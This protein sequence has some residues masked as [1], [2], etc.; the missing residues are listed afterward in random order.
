VCGGN[1]G[2]EAKIGREQSSKAEG[3][4]KCAQSPDQQIRQQK[5]PTSLAPIAISCNWNR[6]RVFTCSEPGIAGCAISFAGCVALA[7]FVLFGDGGGSGSLGA[8]RRRLLGGSITG[9]E[10]WSEGRIHGDDDVIH[11]ELCGW[12]G[13][14]HLLRTY[15]LEADATGRYW[16]PAI[17]K[18]AGTRGR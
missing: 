5:A 11:A 12:G 16:S 2:W 4:K 1:G 14:E 18:N 13:C 7:A 17:R 6:R 8:R 10:R 15:G 3:G 9:R